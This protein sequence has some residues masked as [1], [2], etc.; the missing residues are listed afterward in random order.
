M[1]TGVQ[2]PERNSAGILLRPDSV[3][4]QNRT[5]SATLSVNL[6]SDRGNVYEQVAYLAYVVAKQ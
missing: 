1:C 4:R 3:C 5:S 6:R 2:L